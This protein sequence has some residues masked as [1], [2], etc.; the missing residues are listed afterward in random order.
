MDQSTQNDL[1]EVLGFKSTSSLGKYL[2]FPIKHK[3]HQQDFDF[4]LDQMQSK[5]AGWKD[6]LLSIASRIVLTQSVTST[7]PSYVIQA[8]ALPPKIL[9]GVDRLSRNFIW[10]LSETKKK[11]HL[12]GLN[13]V[14]KAKE[15]GGLGIQAAKPKNIAILAKLNWRFHTEKSSLWVRV[16]SN[17]YCGQRERPRS[18]MTLPSCSLTWAGLKKGEA[19]FLNGS[20]WIAGRNSC[21]SLWFDKW[22]NNGTLRS[23]ISGP[24]NKGEENLNLKEVTS[25]YGWNW[26][27]LYFVFPKPL[28]LEMKATLFLFLIR[29][30]TGS[31][32]THPQMMILN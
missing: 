15:K 30:M 21:L 2:G 20:K 27:G 28:L 29:G 24:L 14:T 18:L 16:L 13:K 11:V 10:G 9:K 26:E 23:L 31:P 4:I 7:I 5:L 3:G 19:T 12:I 8:T 25:F 32:G 22:L 17:K 1:S 6:N